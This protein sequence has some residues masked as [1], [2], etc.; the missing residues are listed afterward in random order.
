VKP[1]TRCYGVGNSFE[2]P[3]KIMAPCADNKLTGQRDAEAVAMRQR[4]L[5]VR[6]SLINE[7]FYKW[8]Q[9]STP[10]A[11][12]ALRE[13]PPEVLAN[14]CI[15]ANLINM[16][17]LGDEANVAYMATQLNIAPAQQHG[18]GQLLVYHDII[19]LTKDLYR[20]DIKRSSGRL[21]W[22]TPRHE[23]QPSILHVHDI[24]L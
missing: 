21:R 1:E 24:R 13:G 16:P 15:N 10:V 17:A 12:K 22:G 3:T 19:A 7:H 8:T 14:I 11:M 18:T 6:V 2:A 4:L 20:R 23:G 9:A 5:K